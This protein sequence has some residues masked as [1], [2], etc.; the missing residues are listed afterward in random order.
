MALEKNMKHA[1]SLVLLLVVIGVAGCSAPDTPPPTF[2][3]GPN[4]ALVTT[5]ALM[6]DVPQ[7]DLLSLHYYPNGP[8]GTE[9]LVWPYVTVD[10]YVV[11]DKLVIFNGGMTEE[12]DWKYYPELLAYD[13]AG[14]VVDISLVAC[15]HIPGAGLEWTN[16]AFSVL[17]VSNG[18]VRLDASQRFPIDNH[19]PKRVAV[20]MD[21][22][23]ILK[24][25]QAAQGNGAPQ[26]FNGIKY[27]IAQ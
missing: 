22:A 4:Y 27:Y 21:E 10:T 16:F 9:S 8:K 7:K 15:R 2:A 11:L 20:E 5:N 26:D 14:S 3:H 24:T 6:G 23:E 19:L 12:V 18:M 17:S 13:G 25:V 1:S